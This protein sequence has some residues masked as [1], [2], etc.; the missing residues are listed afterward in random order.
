MKMNK[1][2]YFR[3]SKN[4]IRLL[5]ENVNEDEV[6]KKIHNFLDEHNYKSY[7]TRSW[8]YKGVTTY[9]VGSHT[10][11]FLYGEEKDVYNEE[12]TIR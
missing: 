12:R 3:D 4:K 11:F 6:F 9:D 2:L 10:E 7:Y 1:N 8:T 5:Y